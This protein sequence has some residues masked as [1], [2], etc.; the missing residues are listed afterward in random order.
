MNFY[1]ILGLI[2]QFFI[3]RWN[4]LILNNFFES[5]DILNEL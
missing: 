1:C 5:Y 3:F 4:V 2:E